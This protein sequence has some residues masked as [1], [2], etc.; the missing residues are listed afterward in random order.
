VDDCQGDADRQRSVGEIVRWVTSAALALSE[1]QRAQL[2]RMAASTV[3]PHRQVIQAR[4]LLWAGD[5]VANE[6]IARR[7]GADSD[8]V[9]RWRKRLKGTAGDLGC[10]YPAEEVK[11]AKIVGSRF[12]SN[13]ADVYRIPIP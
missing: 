5:G 4:A 1:T 7:V 6:E 9:R 3:L 10:D 8:T 12:L 11:L 13:E 2:V